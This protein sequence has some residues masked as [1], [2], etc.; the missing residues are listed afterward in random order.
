MIENG[1]LLEYHTQKE[2][3]LMENWTLD[4]HMIGQDD[5][6]SRCGELSLPV[7][8]NSQSPLGLPEI[9]RITECISKQRCLVSK[10]GLLVPAT[11]ATAR[12][13]NVVEVSHSP[14]T[15]VSF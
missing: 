12:K 14:A 4:R 9:D 13:S 10:A 6:G 5:I 1:Q 2:L 8:F 15:T 11:T 7:N 3:R